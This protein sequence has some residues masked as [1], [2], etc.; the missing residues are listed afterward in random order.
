MASQLHGAV[1]GGRVFRTPGDAYRQD[2]LSCLQDFNLEMPLRLT[3]GLR[4]DLL[5]YREHFARK[6]PT[7][8]L[9]EHQQ[10]RWCVLG[11]GVVGRISAKLQLRWRGVQIKAKNLG[12]RIIFGYRGGSLRDTG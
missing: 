6:P 9:T 4:Q 1:G 2:M 10:Y 12:S 8:L 5:P 3:T 7:L 11:S